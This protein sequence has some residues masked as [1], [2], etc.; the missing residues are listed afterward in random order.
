MQNPIELA[1][2][3]QDIRGIK[4][5]LSADATKVAVIDAMMRL[6]DFSDDTR[7]ALQ[8]MRRDNGESLISVIFILALEEGEA[9]NAYFGLIQRIWYQDYMSDCLDDTHNT[10]GDTFFHILAANYRSTDSDETLREFFSPDDNEIFWTRLNDNQLTP[11]MRACRDDNEFALKLFLRD[12]PDYPKSLEDEMDNLN[13]CHLL[14][15]YFQKSFKSTYLLE[16]I[17]GQ[18]NAGDS[19]LHVAAQSGSLNCVKLLTAMGGEV[20]TR[21][22]AGSTP[23]DLARLNN[24]ADV[25]AYLEL[26]EQIDRAM[27]EF[28]CDGTSLL[29]ML[30]GHNQGELAET[31]CNQYDA[32][33]DFNDEEKAKLLRENLTSFVENTTTDNVF[34]Q[35]VLLDSSHTLNQ[36]CMQAWEHN[37]LRKCLVEKKHEKLHLIVSLLRF[38]PDPDF[39]F[40]DV[41]DLVKEF[42]DHHAQD[43]ENRESVINLL[44]TDQI[45]I[46]EDIEEL[47]EHKRSFSHTP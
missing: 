45:Q 11:A 1:V 14:E 9:D 30:I 26:V 41:D 13:I 21:N 6:K 16:W 18:N 5:F 37:I 33:Q 19:A 28:E 25:I 3:N 47:L 8:N 10:D 32:W 17:N 23:L 43:F 36:R 40:E 4:D 15:N 27:I 12:C 39:D 35:L 29:G 34:V 46:P 38:V 7:E 22:L 20:S 44:S 31:L 42:Q 2:Q 24:H